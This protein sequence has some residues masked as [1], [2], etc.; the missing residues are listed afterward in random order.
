[1]TDDAGRTPRQKARARLRRT[2]RQVAR[3]RLQVER[4]RAQIA[5]LEEEAMTPLQRTVRDAADPETAT[6]VPS[7]TLSA[8]L[9]RRANTTRVYTRETIREP[10]LQLYA[11]LPAQRFAAQHGVR[12]PEILGRWAE[13]GDVDWD[14]LPDR[15]VLKSSIGG[16]GMNVFPLVRDPATGTY[17][18]LLVGEPTTREA[19]LEKL[20]SKHEKRS[21]Y[22]A[23][24]FLV[25]RS[26]EPGAVPDDIKVFCFYGEPF[27]L[28]VR[29]GD[30]SRAANITQRVRAFAIDG[31]ELVNVR[32]LMDP[33]EGDVTAPEDFGAIA[34]ACR[35]L[36]GAIRRPLERLDFFETDQGLV[37]GE[38]TQNSGRPPALV[39]E[40][41]RAM[42]EVYE[43]AYAR[44]LA[45]LAAE[46][47][48]HVTYGEHGDD[49]A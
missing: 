37:F 42:G 22:F 43:N 17:T 39:P 44:L 4:L 25:G 24:E 38:L 26:G 6:G 48:L 7:H 31:T 28:E 40:W 9:H 33:G 18:D 47:A 23:E 46:D 10:I 41:D 32:A 12:V 2:E 45:D 19:V 11:K 29:R 20:W 27:Y 30:Q 34:E 49:P 8:R 1:M 13:P 16:G 35:T 21:W 5:I 3:R 14:A 36:S 15:F